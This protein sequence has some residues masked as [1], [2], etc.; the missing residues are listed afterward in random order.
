MFV[1]IFHTK[2]FSSFTVSCQ[3]FKVVHDDFCFLFCILDLKFEFRQNHNYFVSQLFHWSNVWF[4]FYI[5]IVLDIIQRTSVLPAKL[6][7][8][9]ADGVAHDESSCSSCCSSSPCPH[10]LCRRRVRRDHV[11]WQPQWRRSLMRHRRSWPLQCRYVIMG[12]VCPYRTRC[13]F[14]HDVSEL[15]P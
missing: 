2:S 9:A 14:T 11:R 6:V 4:F 10:L 13:N 8:T 12:H 1:S 3:N 15:H 7:D 5:L